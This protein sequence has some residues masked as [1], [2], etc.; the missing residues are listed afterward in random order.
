MK[1]IYKNLK[2]N[3]YIIYHIKRGLSKSVLLLKNSNIAKNQ[4]II[5]NIYKESL[6]TNDLYITQNLIEEYDKKRISEQNEY[7]NIL[8]NDLIE[9]NDDIYNS[10]ILSLFLKYIKIYI[11]SSKKKN[12]VY[13]PLNYIFTLLYN[14]LMLDISEKKIK[15]YLYL[16]INKIDKSDNIIIEKKKMKIKNDI[17]NIWVLSLE[18]NKMNLVKKSMCLDIFKSLFINKKPP[19]WDKHKTSNIVYNSNINID[20]IFKF[21]TVNSFIYENHIR[22]N[23]NLKYLKWINILQ[24]IGYK[25]NK[26]LFIKI[27]SKFKLIDYYYSTSNKIH[28]EIS[29]EV[30]LKHFHEYLYEKKKKE[31]NNDFNKI[32]WYYNEKINEIKSFYIKKNQHGVDE[33]HI[34][35]LMS[36]VFIYL[37]K[38]D[39]KIY[40][41]YKIDMRG[42]LYHDG[43][44]SYIGIKLIRFLS[45][46]NR[47]KKRK[48]KKTL[49][50]KNNEKVKFKWMNKYC[51]FYFTRQL[52]KR[53]IKS[54]SE[55]DNLFNKYIENIVSY[56]DLVEKVENEN[57]DL[58]KK[59]NILK[60]LY[61]KKNTTISL[62][63]S[64]SM[65]QI[66]GLISKNRKLMFYTNTLMNV[67]VQDIY[68]Y[69]IT[70]IKKKISEKNIFYDYYI[71]RK[72]VKYICMTYIYGSTAFSL[73]FEMK[74]LFHLNNI[75][76]E[77][78]ITISSEI[79]KTFD[80]EFPVV[81]K[82]KKYVNFY[83]DLLAVDK[84]IKYDIIDKKLE[85]NFGK[86]KR[87]N[88][89][90]NFNDEK[91][92]PLSIT[93]NVNGL[94]HDFEKKK[95]SGL[96]NI[97]HS[98]DA[99]LAVKTR[100]Y[101]LKNNIESLSIHDCFMVNIKHYRQC[102]RTYNKYLSELL[103]YDIYDIVYELNDFDNFIYNC[104]KDYI[105]YKEYDKLV[106]IILYSINNTKNKISN[107]I[108]ILK[109]EMIEFEKNNF[110]Q[111]KNIIKK[112]N[113]YIE[114]IDDILP[115]LIINVYKKKWINLKSDLENEETFEISEKNLII[116]N[117][118]SLLPE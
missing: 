51:I 18:K 58:I 25:L 74:E 113:K 100:I 23:I 17:N 76:I 21:I 97:I 115:Q 88:L 68:E 83:I 60:L 52:N 85:Y 107:E 99:E 16:L 102:V 46:L 54:F 106:D 47:K 55:S 93:L 105:Q 6:S 56:N 42:R 95:K 75:L 13:L 19:K 39:D 59:M 32:K 81:K 66:I 109:A 5:L 10:K 27:F 20:N 103:K 8:F 43:L 116:E 15:E 63:A 36:L 22:K 44:V 80:I 114:N 28:I 78:L 112:I 82:L 77:D 111:E 98:I 89:E 86:K 14:S 104:I 65:L 110:F 72:I 87:V 101:L 57:I 53:K 2:S 35:D 30:Y 11:I 64:S 117:Y 108:K 29:E 49:N 94:K 4:K 96:V 84:D 7:I 41:L 92:E 69:L 12:V 31:L 34:N 24:E 9:K 61:I 40:N 62:D 73:S 26:K 37:Y 91:K 71:N 3:N 1:I 90:Y 67:E 79:I 48:K 45:Y 50:K 33:L 118:F 38:S 70:I